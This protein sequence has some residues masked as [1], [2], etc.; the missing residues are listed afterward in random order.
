MLMYVYNYSIGKEKQKVKGIQSKG[1][2]FTDAEF[3]FTTD[4]GGVIIEREDYAMIENEKELAYESE[5][6]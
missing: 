1:G 3:L 6:G 2:K 4:Y 5:A